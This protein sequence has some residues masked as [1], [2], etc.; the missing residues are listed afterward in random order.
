MALFSCHHYAKTLVRIQ[1]TFTV[2]ILCSSNVPVPSHFRSRLV[3]LVV[4]NV[5]H[6]GELIFFR[7]EY[8]FIIIT[9]KTITILVIIIV[10]IR[11]IKPEQSVDVTAEGRPVCREEHPGNRTLVSAVVPLAGREVISES[12]CE[13][14]K[15]N[16]I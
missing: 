8:F 10:F 9:T 1:K 7:Q 6:L 11:T 5:V 12:Q 4:T 2:R 13:E 16:V 15:N 3:G 14:S